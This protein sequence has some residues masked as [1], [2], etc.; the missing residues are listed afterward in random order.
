MAYSIPFMIRRVLILVKYY[1]PNANI[2]IIKV[3]RENYK[4]VRAAIML[5]TQIN[6]ENKVLR[7]VV[8]SVKSV[9]GS[10]RT[11]KVSTL[12]LLLKWFHE[13][14]QVLLSCDTKSNTPNVE[15]HDS[16]LK[17]LQSSME[18]VYLLD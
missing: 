16:W 6:D 10:A 8:L 1:H 4:L 2:F 5:I 18:E 12:R 14:I 15:I 13:Q 3:P 7:P 11:C 9:H 17:A